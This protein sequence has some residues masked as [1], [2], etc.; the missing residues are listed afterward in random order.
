[1]IL[2]V[3]LKEFKDKVLQVINNWLNEKIQFPSITINPK[4]RPIII[5]PGLF[6]TNILMNKK[7]GKPL[8]SFDDSS[9]RSERRKTSKLKKSSGS[10]LVYAA[11]INL[12]E[13][14]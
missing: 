12:C 13:E 11:S 8:T 10:E 5:N 9:E 14:G 7:K 2:H 3:Y 6:I 4:P 1:M